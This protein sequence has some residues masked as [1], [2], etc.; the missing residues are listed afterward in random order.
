MGSQLMSDSESLRLLYL[1]F[2]NEMECIIDWRNAA[3][4]AM[5]NIELLNLHR[6]PKL[7]KLFEAEVCQGSLRKL[8]KIE[9]KFCN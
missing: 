7:K 4:N 9:V 1:L 5:K 8:K 2:C 6:L 3:E